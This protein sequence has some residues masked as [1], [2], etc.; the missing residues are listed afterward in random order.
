MAVI[1][2]VVPI[3]PGVTSSGD[4]VEFGGQFLVSSGGAIVS[5][6]VTAGGETVIYAGG[7]AVGT[8]I[9]ND[10]GN[11]QVV[12]GGVESSTLVGDGGADLVATG[13]TFG[14]LVLRG[15]LEILGAGA[16]GS[17]IGVIGSA[18][19]AEGMTVDG[20]TARIN[21]DTT[22]SGTTV[23][24]GGVLDVYDGGTDSHASVGSGGTVAVSFGG[25]DRGARVTSDGILN[26][27]SGGVVSA[28][29]IKDPNDPMVAAETN[30]RRG[31]T[32]D[33]NTKINGG[34]LILHAGAVFEANA[35]L[36]IINTGWLVLKEGSFDGTIKDFGGQDNLDLT[37]ISFIGSG[38][39]AT[40]ANWTQTTAAAGTLQVAEGT[41]SV[42]LQLDG[43]YTT[44][45]FALASAG[46]HGTLVTFVP[47]ASLAG[48]G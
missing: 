44:A 27:Q 36:T 17:G 33:G 26:V 11:G 28:L 23:V 5:A 3:G 21:G 47:S 38:P 22:A 34:E 6:T 48:H 16:G 1:T 9:V 13:V 40:T 43:I 25:I 32:V 35:T 41:H 46:A 30:I 2:T 4:F 20:G 12:S 15:G 10:G 37:K 29:T 8:T 31:G 7:I 14:A 24:D 18:A 19:L 45:N 42:D 39:D